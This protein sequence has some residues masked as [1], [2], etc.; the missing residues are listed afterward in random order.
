MN[1]ANP[2]H[3]WSVWIMLTGVLSGCATYEK[4][5]LEGCPSDQRTTS[6]VEALLNKHAEFGAPG[7]ITVKTV[8]GVVYLDGLVD[9]GLEKRSAESLVRQAF[10]V[11]RVVNGIS[12]LH[13]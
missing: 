5:E 11:T 10:G 13:D 6:K 1:K 7:S 9:G 3:A 8:N 12:V 4:C 2:A